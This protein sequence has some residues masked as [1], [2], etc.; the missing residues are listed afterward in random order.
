M[1]LLNNGASRYLP[2]YK[3]LSLRPISMSIFQYVANVN[4]ETIFGAALPF[5]LVTTMALR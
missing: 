1:K 4:L 2:L 5:K 3:I